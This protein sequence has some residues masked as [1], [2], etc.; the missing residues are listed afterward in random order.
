MARV[1]VEDCVLKVPNRFELVMLA[2]RRARAVS[3]GAALTVER[4]NDK[5]PVIALREIAKGS[6]ELKDLKESLIKDQQKH[7]EFDQP[8][9]E[10]I[11]LSAIQQAMSGELAKA[12]AEAKPEPMLE[13][14]EGDGAE[15]DAG[16]ATDADVDADVAGIEP[17]SAE[18]NKEE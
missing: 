18:D 3:A 8:E 7:V 15:L 11:D 14:E 17:A 2:S 1:T 13:D 6:V 10:E 5:N 16:A 9:E 4:D 12:V